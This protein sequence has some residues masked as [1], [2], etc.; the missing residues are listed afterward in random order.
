MSANPKKP[1]H[2][3]THLTDSWPSAL[4]L[5][6]EVSERLKGAVTAERLL[7]LAAAGY[8][9]HYRIDGGPPMFVITEI[10]NWMAKNILERVSGKQLPEIV[11]VAIPMAQ[12]GDKPPVSIAGLPGL[13]QIP[14][15]DLS[16]GVYFLCSGDEVVYVGQSIAP[17]SRLAQHRMDREKKFD[18]AYLLPTPPSEMN[19]VEGA[20]IRHLRPSQQGGLRNGKANPVAPT[21]SAPHG[22][23]VD[24]L[25]SRSGQEPYVEIE[26]PN[27]LSVQEAK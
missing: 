24:A 17:M 14:V 2:V 6:E 13:A 21:T 12:F 25:F 27:P 10:R 20:F 3:V 23:I 11:R 19:D 26:R 9:P 7:E 16:P 15:N 18:R 5:A 8:A 1:E 4:L 22:D